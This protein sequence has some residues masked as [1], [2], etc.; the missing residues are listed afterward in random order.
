MFVSHH[1]GAH[2]PRLD[3]P[4]RDLERVSRAAA[5]VARRSVRKTARILVEGVK[6]SPERFLVCDILKS[7]LGTDNRWDNSI[8]NMYDCTTIPLDLPDN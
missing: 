1:S 7:V 4:A 8:R 5:R 3:S 2:P 6:V